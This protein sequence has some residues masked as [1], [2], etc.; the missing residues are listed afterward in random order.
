MKKTA[1]ITITVLSLVIGVVVLAADGAEIGWSVLSGGGGAVQS[2][3]LTLNGTI[4][5]IATGEVTSGAVA[6][7]S[8]YWC[9]PPAQT[10]YL[11]AIVK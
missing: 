5:Q 8:G 11:P 1:L 4:G 7:C 2:G 9:A 6:L 3:S 10:I